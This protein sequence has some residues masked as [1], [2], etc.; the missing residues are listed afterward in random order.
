MILMDDFIIDFMTFSDKITLKI[1]IFGC[2]SLGDYSAIQK[3]WF[4]STI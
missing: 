1:M 3:L 2:S 4:F